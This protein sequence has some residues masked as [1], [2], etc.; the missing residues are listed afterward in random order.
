MWRADERSVRKIFLG[1]LFVGCGNWNRATVLGGNSGSGGVGSGG[2]AG[3]P[4]DVDQLL[5][6][7]CRSCHGSPPSGGAPMSL[8]NYV[9]LVSPAPS[10]PSQRVIDVAIA[11]MQDAARPMPPA[12]L[13]QASDVALLQNWLAAGLPMGPCSAAGANTP[14]VCTSGNTWT[15]GDDGSSRMHPGMACISCH[16]QTGGEAPLFALAGT[17]YPTAHEPDDCYGGGSAISGAQVVITDANGATI[18][19]TPNSAG[20][21]SSRAAIALPFRAKVVR[22]GAERAMAAAQSDGDCNGCHTVDG[23]NGA[24]GRIFVP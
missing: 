16:S 18:T 1:L 20:N 5:S 11:R 9:D 14:T 8:D 22:N 2:P 10:D 12:G 3:M 23:A 17:V 19:L 15:G 7:Q 6:L 21:F 24:P 13:L 4:C